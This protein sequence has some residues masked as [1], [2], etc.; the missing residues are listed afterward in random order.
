MRKLTRDR[1]ETMRDEMLIKQA[2]TRSSF[3]VA[4]LSGFGQ[5]VKV[6]EMRSR[7]S[8]GLVFNAY[9]PPFPVVPLEFLTGLQQRGTRL[10]EVT[11]KTE[12]L[13]LFDLL[14]D[15]GRLEKHGALI[16]GANS[17]TGFGKTQYALRVACEWSKAMAQ[18]RGLSRDSAR[19]AFMNSLDAARDVEFAPGMALVLDEFSPSDSESLVYISET[20]LK[21]L[22]CPSTPGTIRARNQEIKLCEGVARILTA[23][24]STASEWCGRSIKWSDPLARKTMVFQVTAPLCSRVWVN[25]LSSAVS[26]CGPSQQASILLRS[27]LAAAGVEAPVQQPVAPTGLSSLLCPRRG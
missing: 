22:M 14:A 21:V 2:K 5:L 12:H 16:L 20:M 26:S 17:T 13:T 9:D 8:Q 6:K 24:A 15:A 4:F 19:V 1:V 23:N 10:Q 27:R 3:E 11:R 25:S 18:A 7:G